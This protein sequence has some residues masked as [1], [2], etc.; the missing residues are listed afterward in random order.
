ME[1]V[2]ILIFVLV[3]VPYFGLPKMYDTPI[4]I[5]TFLLLAYSVYVFVKY[6][7]EDMEK[8]QETEK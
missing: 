5:V 7:I 8:E 4:Y 6:H 1:R 2:F 3:S